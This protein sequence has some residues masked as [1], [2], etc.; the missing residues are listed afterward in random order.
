MDI[1][2]LFDKFFWVIFAVVLGTFAWKVLRHGGMRGAMFGSRIERLVGEVEGE[3]QAMHSFKVRV[4][5]LAGS[6]D[7]GTVELELV[8]KS[9]ASYQMTPV[10]L[11]REAALHLA[12]HLRVA[13][14]R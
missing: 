9:V 14:T 8:A 12:E 1:D 2:S 6:E 4:H 7:K 10:T 5:K 11:S 3:K 13:A